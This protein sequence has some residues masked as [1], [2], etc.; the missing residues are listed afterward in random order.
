VDVQQR[1]AAA[2]E[3]VSADVADL[4]AR[5]TELERMLKEVG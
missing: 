4:R 2:L 1:H 5:T 3:K